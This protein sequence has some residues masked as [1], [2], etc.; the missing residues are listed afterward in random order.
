M[1][2]TISRG[3]E[4]DLAVSVTA[5]TLGHL[6]YGVIELGT[7]PAREDIILEA[8]VLR[9]LAGRIYDALRE[10]DAPELG[11]T[12]EG[13]EKFEAKAGMCSYCHGT[14]LEGG[15]PYTER[16][17][18]LPNCDYCG[19]TGRETEEGDDTPAL[20]CDHCYQPVVVVGSKY[21]HFD[22]DEDEDD[23][24]RGWFWCGNMAG[25]YSLRTHCEVN[26]RDTVPEDVLAEMTAAEVIA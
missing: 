13:W 25:D 20:V 7:Y 24:S 10:L 1:T 23:P 22:P 18:E 26:G 12:H 5:H 14:G 15:K 9:V 16:N 2:V 8:E 17:A 19:G 21:K 6:R 4:H 11:V 3:G